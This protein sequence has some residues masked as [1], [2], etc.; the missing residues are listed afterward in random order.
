VFAASDMQAMG[1]MRAAQEAGLRVPED[2]ALVG[3]DDIELSQCA[4][5]T[6]LRQPARTMGTRAAETL[7]RRI[8]TPGDS[9][10]SS[11]VFS[12]KLV[13]RRTCGGRDEP[14]DTS[15]VSALDGTA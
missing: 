3:F 15:V 2:L 9:P 12:P 14:R 5:L 1:A 13:V 4:G 8:D 10:V 6:T 11:T 7:L